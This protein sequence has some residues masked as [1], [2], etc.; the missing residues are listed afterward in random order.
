MRAVIKVYWNYAQEE[1]PVRLSP[2]PENSKD[3]IAIAFQ[4]CVDEKRRRVGYVV[5]EEVHDG[6][7]SSAIRTVKFTWAKFLPVG[8]TVDLVIML[9]LTYQRKATAQIMLFVIEVPIKL[10]VVMWSWN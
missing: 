4:Y 5:N 3:S 2:E 7:A 1:V 6:L 9:E 10:L 8:V